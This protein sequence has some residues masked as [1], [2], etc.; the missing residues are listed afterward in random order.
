MDQSDNNYSHNLDGNE[1]F[2]QLKRCKLQPDCSSNESKEINPPEPKIP[3]NLA[4]NQ[5]Y[6]VTELPLLT[7]KQF[8]EQQDDRTSDEDVSKKYNEYKIQ[9]EQECSKMNKYT[10]LK[11][12]SVTVSLTR[13]KAQIEKIIRTYGSALGVSK[14]RHLVEESTIFIDKSLLIK[15]FLENKSKVLIITCPRTFGKSINID[16]IKNFLEIQVDENGNKFS[17]KKETTNYKLFC[18]EI[19]DKPLNIMLDDEF[20]EIYDEYQGEYPVIYVNFSKAR[21]TTHQEILK[22]IKL[23]IN[24]AFKQH[25]YIIQRLDNIIKNSSSLYS[26]KKIAENSLKKFLKIYEDYGQN[27]DEFNIQNSLS[28]LSELLYNHL[29][30]KVFILIDDYDAPLNSAILNNLDIDKINHIMSKIFCNAFKSNHYLKKG[31]ITGT[32]GIPTPSA[33]GG[34]NNFT[35]YKF[36]D[37]HEFTKYYGFTQ[38]EVLELINNSRFKNYEQVEEIYKGYLAKDRDSQEF[39]IYN[40]WSIVKYIEIGTLDNYWVSTGSIKNL[41]N[42]FTIDQIRNNFIKLICGQELELLFESNMKMYDLEILQQ[43]L[44]FTDN[45]SLN[46][47][48]LFFSF[49]YELGY[50]SLTSNK[51]FY[52]IPNQE[53]RIEFI[54]KIIEYY[55]NTYDLSREDFNDTLEQLDYLFENE[56][57]ED[58]SNFKFALKNLF[59]VCPKENVFVSLL[60]IMVIKLKNN[61]FGSKAWS[62][63]PT[64]D[65]LILINDKVKLA[66]YIELKYNGSEDKAPNQKFFFQ[67]Y[68]FI[69]ALKYIR[70][71]LSEDKTIDVECKLEKNQN[72]Q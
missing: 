49:I 16:M 59:R 54:D 53:I 1:S 26:E 18:G 63:K 68:N 42:F 32:S 5:P 48:D 43:M 47:S 10:E 52:K 45:L 62:K 27:A 40:P 6:H 22:G 30:K 37:R 28:F 56:A 51:G 3:K 72:T 66:M 36:L 24:A 31:L 41:F 67:E 13:K 9:L 29:G 58:T 20:S 34:F 46:R 12:E 7:F 15:E 21:Q 35:E 50:L 60:N 70:I 8:I 17:N 64:S 44:N 4:Q 25:K 2:N 61:K 14:F 69:Q 39:Y 33:T 38:D 71:N 65:N 19:L 57:K 23:V 55:L 11:T